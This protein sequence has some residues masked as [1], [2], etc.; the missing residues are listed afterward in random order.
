MVSDASAD[1]AGAFARF[2]GV[3]ELFGA[4]F[5]AVWGLFSTCSAGEMGL[6]C[7][8]KPLDRPLGRQRPRAADGRRLSA[9]CLG[10]VNGASRRQRDLHLGHG[11][12]DPFHGR[13]VLRPPVQVRPN[14]A[15]IAVGAGR[16][17]AELVGR[18]SCARHG[19]RLAQFCDARAPTRFDPKLWAVRQCRRLV[20]RTADQR[21]RR[22]FLESAA[23][24]AFSSART[25]SMTV[26][27]LI[28]TPFVC[29]SRTAPGHS[30]AA[31]LSRP[32]RGPLEAG[33]P[34][35]RPA[36]TG[37]RTSQRAVLAC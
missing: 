17:F 24:T 15:G 35:G 19:A 20:R 22:R 13:R 21:V 26:G 32:S 25:T 18:Q 4:C 33:H 37:L 11:S 31:D 36:P 27:R 6:G 7:R 2:E 12:L 10:G 1:Q 34:T 8:F 3:F 28:P 5:R 30:P 23:L 9:S 29:A 14:G 16:N